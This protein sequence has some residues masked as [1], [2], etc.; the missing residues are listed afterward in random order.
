VNA[1]PGTNPTAR[2][3]SW[4]RPIAIATVLIA[5]ALAGG[6]YYSLFD[7]SN[8]EL[9]EAIAE[10]DRLDPGWR[11]EDLESAR[12]LVPP[13]ENSA[14]HILAAR[15]L[16]P[17]TF[18][19]SVLDAEQPAPTAKLSKK[20]REDLAA[21]L[22]Q[23]TEALR[24]VRK[25]VGMPRGRY[26]IKW[27][28]DGVGTMLPHYDAVILMMRL[29]VHD[30]MLRADS[31]DSAGV[32]ESVKA[33]IYVG[34][35]F[36]DEPVRGTQRGRLAC[37]VLTLGFLERILA[38][39]EPTPGELADLQHLLEDEERHPAQLIAAR[40]ERAMVHQFLL[41]AERMEIDRANYGM[42][43]SML[44]YRFDNL[45]DMMK[46]KQSHAKYLQFLNENVEIAKLPAHEQASK[47]AN[48]GSRPD[49][50][51]ALLEGLTRG[52][53]PESTMRFFHLSLA[54]LRCGIVAL[55]VTRYRQTEGRWPD[56]LNA[57][58][59]KYLSD[60]PCDPFEGKPLQLIRFQEEAGVSWM[61]RASKIVPEA[62]PS[63]P[64]SFRLWE[65]PPASFRLWELKDRQK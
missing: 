65:P 30:A 34:R 47:I 50:L 38:Q 25:V 17:G 61:I 60:V 3:V 9:R 46:A 5:M 54:R 27:S 11:F 33:M 57:L 63:P 24:E 32:L 39:A 45:L 37:S 15:L 55:A 7:K 20:E 23:V 29:L 43:A 53:E 28:K 51:P 26:S 13:Q 41:A 14:S 56:D 10:A 48:L 2:R 35:S 42:R 49:Q 40:A 6:T 19:R 62:P 52:D 21:E 64:T 44:G 4:R 59:P 58:V 18:S 1:I 12:A 36:G 22:G 31:G 16:I 8:R